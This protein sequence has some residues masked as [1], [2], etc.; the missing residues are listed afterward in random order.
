MY[1]ILV[2]YLVWQYDH[3]I[4]IITDSFLYLMIYYYICDICHKTLNL[5]VNV[6]SVSMLLTEQYYF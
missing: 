3:V 6:T 1:E 5:V 2:L 4:S